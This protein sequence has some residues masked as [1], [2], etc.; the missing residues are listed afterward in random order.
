MAAGGDL[1]FIE[2]CV[3]RG[4]PVGTHMPVPESAYVRDYVSPAGDEWVERF[5][6][7]RN[8]P[9]VDEYYRVGWH[10]TGRR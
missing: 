10:P 4:I 9:L 3:N 8:H 7:M 1:L 5:Y 6:K 2:T